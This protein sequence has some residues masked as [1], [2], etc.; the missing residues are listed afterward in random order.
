MLGR[1]FGY[2]KA[3]AMPPVRPEVQFHLEVQVE[4]ET[5]LKLK[6]RG[7]FET[8]STLQRLTWSCKVGLSLGVQK[9]P[10][11]RLQ[12]ALRC[13]FKLK[14][15]LQYDVAAKGFWS[16]SNRYSVMYCIDGQY[17]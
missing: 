17:Q 9:M 11:Q 2:N 4:V 8:Q 6:L 16:A 5:R 13:E 7:T 10:P 14:L 12:F 3:A 1:V 15:K